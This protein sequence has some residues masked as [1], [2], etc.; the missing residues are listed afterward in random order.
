MKPG[1]QPRKWLAKKAKRGVAGYPAGTVAFYGPDN[2]RATKAAVGVIPAAQAEPSEMRRW[3]VEDG[4]VR[5]N[6]AI[7]D[8]V[9]RFLRDAG[10]R[11]VIVVDRVIGCPHE[12]GIDYPSGRP[13]PH[14][15]YWAGRDRWTGE[16]ES[17]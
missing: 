1:W 8:E 17:H 3:L 13:C 15:P 4:D 12:E 9:A 14:C 5:T 11:S 6:E 7:L 16:P 10:V 2:R